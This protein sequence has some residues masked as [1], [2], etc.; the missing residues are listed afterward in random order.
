MNRLL[1]ALSGLLLV[2]IAALVGRE[3][4]ERARD[5]QERWLEDLEDELTYGHT[6]I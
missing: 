5:S 2:G 4:V 6:G 3:L 1:I